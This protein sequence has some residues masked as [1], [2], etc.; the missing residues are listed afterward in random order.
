VD[1]GNKNNANIKVGVTH[2]KQSQRSRKGASLDVRDRRVDLERLGDRD[3]TLGAEPVTRQ[4]AKR[5]GNKKRNDRNVVTVAVTKNA[6]LKVGVTH[7]KQRQRGRRGASLDVRDR[8]VDLE[9]LGD[10]DA[11]LGAEIVPLQAAKRE[12]NKKG[13]FGMLLP[14]R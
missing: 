11:T 13:M 9:R 3:A 1:R 5:G 2:A 12:G 8:R 10:R 4:S 14:S 7:A 6:N